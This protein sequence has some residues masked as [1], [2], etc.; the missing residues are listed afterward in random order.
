MLVIFHVF[1]SQV[2]Q[3]FIDIPNIKTS[4]SI[5][6]LD[7]KSVF[8]IIV[9]WFFLK[10]AIQFASLNVLSYRSDSYHRSCRGVLGT[11]SPKKSLCKKT[12]TVVCKGANVLFTLFVF[13]CAQWCPSHNVFSIF[14]RLV[15]P[16]LAVSLECPFLISLS[17]FSNMYLYYIFVGI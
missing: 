6:Y 2:A 15:Y 4:Y 17:L 3:T 1:L 11:Q 14:L 12:T 5:T 10:I 8:I 7:G 16:M 9:G 13:A